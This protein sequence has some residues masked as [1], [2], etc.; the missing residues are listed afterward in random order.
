M[1]LL[2]M[3]VPGGEVEIVAS[4]AV[5]VPGPRLQPLP[6]AHRAASHGTTTS[7]RTAVHPIHHTAAPHAHWTHAHGAHAAAHV[8]S[9]HSATTTH[10]AHAH[11]EK[12]ITVY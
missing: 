10:S 12:N 6:A 1:A 11:P 3:Q 9:G 7:H 5:P 2:L 8:H 4:G